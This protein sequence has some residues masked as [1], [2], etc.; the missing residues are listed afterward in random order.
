MRRYG[1]LEKA[2][3]TLEEIQDVLQGNAGFQFW[4]FQQQWETIAGKTLAKESYIGNRDGSVLYV[5]VTNSVWMQ[6]LMMHRAVLLKKIQEDPYGSQF[7]EIRLMMA[8]PRRRETGLDAVDRMRKTYQD[9]DLPISGALTDQEK[10]WIIQWVRRHV[11]KEELR[12]PFIQMMEG[13]LKRRKSELSEGWHPCRGCGGLC[14]KEDLLC[15]ACEVQAA[16]NTRHR[17]VLLLKK[18]PELHYEAVRQ[19]IACT[20][21]EFS[22]ARDRLIHRYKEN[23]YHGYGNQE[24]MRRLLSLLI[25]KPFSEISGEEA[26]RVLSALPRK[27][28]GRKVFG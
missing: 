20:Y 6:E 13:A 2:A 23:Y 27:Y 3:Q 24:E 7:R 12:E 18:K 21:A 14:R 16:R 5:Y 25:H 28:T 19:V 9:G 22:E 4:K 8:P 17:I 26:E 10:T 11:V 15:P 1:N